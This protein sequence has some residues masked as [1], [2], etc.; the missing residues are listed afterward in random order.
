[1]SAFVEQRDAAKQALF[2][3]SAGA[4]GAAS[5]RVGDVVD[6]PAPQTVAAN[7][8]AAL[9]D[10]GACHGLATEIETVLHGPRPPAPGDTRE[11]APSS[12]AYLA[13]EN[14]RGLRLLVERLAQIRASLA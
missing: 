2:G 14:A 12:L 3:G 6:R 5:G 9:N 8:H 10:L 7:I 1:M 4:Y 11:T 13:E